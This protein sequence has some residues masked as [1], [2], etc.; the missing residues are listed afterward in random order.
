MKNGENA[1]NLSAELKCWI[2]H[3]QEHFYINTE[4]NKTTITII[5]EHTWGVIGGNTEPYTI[6][7][8]LKK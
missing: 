3:I 1:K 8:G 4:E 2:E 7:H 5:P 6:S